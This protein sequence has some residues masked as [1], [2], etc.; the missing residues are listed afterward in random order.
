ML[1]TTPV[2]TVSLG[3]RMCARGLDWLFEHRHLAALPAGVPPELVDL[4]AFKTL[5]EIALAARVVLR[6]GATGTRA[7]GTARDL[8]DHAWQQFGEGDVLYQIQASNPATTHAI[9]SYAHFVPAGYRH[10]PLDRLCAHLATT[11]SYQVPEIVPNRQIGLV[12]AARRLG[13]PPHHDLAALLDRTW[14][15]GTPEPWL[16]TTLNAYSLT[17]TVFHLTDTGDD[18]SGVPEALQEYL[19]RWL[20]AW[21]E[22]YCETGF[23]DLLGELL[24]VDACLPEPL[25]YA[26]AW[27]LFAEAQREDGMMPNGLTHPPAEPE[28][29]FRNHCHPTVVAVVAGT[30]AAARG[31]DGVAR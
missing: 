29:A 19:R 22:V 30:L 11:R 27:Q 12:G 26:P 17:H 23:W 31:L 9:E 10:P 7:S 13:L 15:G 3:E 2:T 14:L 8:L 5:S 25:W 20:P 21:L 28:H 24:I 4:D 18:P 1:L 6:G 16:L